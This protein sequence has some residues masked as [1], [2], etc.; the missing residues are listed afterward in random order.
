MLEQISLLARAA[1]LAIIDIYQNNQP[2]YV[3]HKDHDLSPVTTADLQAHKIIRDGLLK[4][5]PEIPILSEEDPP[6]WEMRRHWYR[7]WL[8]DPL[9]GTKEFLS[10]NGEF[11][12]NIALIE[13]GIPIM[14]VVYAPSSDVLYYAE[15]N[16]AW[17][18]NNGSI[19]K[20]HVRDARPPLV[21][22]SRSHLDDELRDYL[23]QLGDHQTVA[24]GSSL[25]FCLV[26]EGMAQLYPR[27]G[28]TNIWDTAAGHAIACAAGAKV[29]DWQGKSLDYTPAQFFLNPGF[30]VSIF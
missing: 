14:G 13:D 27:F 6:D 7:Y 4:I 15:R 5:T 23:S 8:V 17:K 30:R 21:V 10:R 12:V 9:D 16:I 1:G 18:K 26:A 3:K 2:F 28:Q 24:V 25:K 19:E 22:V 11:T 29:H 20:I